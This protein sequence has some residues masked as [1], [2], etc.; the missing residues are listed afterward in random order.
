[1][2]LSFNV[3]REQVLSKVSQYEIW[4]RVLGR[5]PVVG[6]P[7]R[8][9]LRNDS[10]PS[11]NFYNRSGIIYGYDYADSI[12]RGDCIHFYALKYFTTYDE[13]KI[14]IM[15]NSVN[16]AKEVISNRVNHSSGKSMIIQEGEL[17]PKLLAYWQDYGVDEELLISEK[18]TTA[19]KA[20]VA[21]DR[22]EFRLTVDQLNFVYHCD[23][24]VK[25]YQPYNKEQKF[26][27][28]TNKHSI[29]GK[30]DDTKIN[31][32]TKANKDRLALISLFNRNN[33]EGYNVIAPNSEAYEIKFE[34]PVI[35]WYDNDEKG[36]IFTEKMTEINE[37]SMYI[38]CKHEKDPSDEIKAFGDEPILKII[39]NEFKFF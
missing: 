11:L 25:L 9:P 32:V 23:D 3:S 38:F 15:N 28:T 4:Q 35:I 6:S 12:Y 27:G 31:I 22:N 21:N 17:T 19:K 24:K 26:L 2:K 13:A 39:E 8:N 5:L 10:S 37:G 30:F 20:W 14:A 29:Y 1:M 33:I 16:I 7:I 18:V 36:R 34:K